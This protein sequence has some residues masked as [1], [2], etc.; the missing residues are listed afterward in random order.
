M[1]KNYPF[2]FSFFFFL[3]NL[4]PHSEKNVSLFKNQDYEK[5]IKFHVYHSKKAI[6]FSLFRV[7]LQANKTLSKT[8]VNSGKIQ[9][10][11]A[12]TEVTHTLK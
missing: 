11:S 12:A 2:Y 9:L 6:S 10:E 7:W 1:F 3:R 5:R 4:F 8:K